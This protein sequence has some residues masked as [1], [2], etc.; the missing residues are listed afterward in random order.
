VSKTRLLTNFHSEIDNYTQFAP[1]ALSTVLNLAG[2]KGRST[3]PRYAVS[4]AL[5]FAFMA[6]IV[7]PLKYS[8]K[9]M[10]P[11]GSTANS[12]PSGHTAT[13]FTAATIL[14]KEYGMTRSPWYSV[15]AYVVAT[16]TGA[17]RV[18]NNRHWVSDVLSGAGVGIMSTELGYAIADLIFKGKGLNRNDLM[19]HPNLI[20]QPSFFSVNM[21]LGLGNKTLDFG[22]YEFKFRSSTVLGVE[23]AY[24]LN[25]Y[26]GVGGRLRM[27]TT[28]IGNFR[29]FVEEDQT[30]LDNTIDKIEDLTGN[31]PIDYAE[32]TI[33]QDH[34]TEFNGA[35][36][37]Y[38]NYPL[39]ERFA[40]GTKL[41]VGYDIMSSLNVGAFGTGTETY[42]NLD[43][44]ADWD[45]LSIDAD[46]AMTYGTGLSLTYSYRSNFSWK[47]F[48]EY[49]FSRKNYT[50]TYDPHRWMKISMSEE[51]A[52]RVFGT[53]FDE[54]KLSVK[55]NMNTFV[56]GGSF[57]VSF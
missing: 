9:E 30:R 23:G 22:D 50:M 37:V 19:D 46:N 53:E 32:L 25:K 31:M 11:D 42:S 15:G 6:A 26:I 38:L 13:V 14:H 1:F 12:W 45:Y 55:K 21:G 54:E 18:L 43:W 27:R 8:V 57:V 4:S 40:L 39:S 56:I 5:S 44:S 10:R 47:I 24:F 29:E 49:D 28:P 7:N 51:V 16:A 36:G 35:A 3:F 34:L 2:V 33:E 52:N 48:M 17:M 41:L 20:E